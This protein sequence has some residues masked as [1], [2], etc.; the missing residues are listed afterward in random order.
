M[1]ERAINAFLRAVRRR[2]WLENALRALP[3]AVWVGA[4]V[5][6]TVAAVSAFLVPV[7]PVTAVIAAILAMLA[8]E[9]PAATRRPDL[10]TSALRA[11]RR[12]EGQALLA[13]AH[14]A[15]SNGYAD[16]PAGELVVQRAAAAVESW[17]GRLRSVWARPNP[18]PFV[19]ALI[20][21]FGAVLF[22]SKSDDVAVDAQPSAGQVEAHRV[23]LGAEQDVAA[24]RE[25][26][27][28][29]RVAS[30]E[31]AAP[32]T[33]DPDG[34]V[35]AIPASTTPDRR[36]IAASQA[37]QPGVAG[38]SAAGGAEA[39]D[40][41]RRPGQLAQHSSDVEF[42]DIRFRQIERRGAANAGTGSASIVDAPTGIPAS[43]ADIQ[44]AAAPPGIAS[45]NAMSA[46]QRAYARRYSGDSNDE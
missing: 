14:D 21:L 40:A 32:M 7:S 19:L 43:L 20:P 28:R 16:S 39:G 37:D 18:A 23:H 35:A 36:E 22:F 33:A 38:E 3:S 31:T 45:W 15:I 27:V 8:I 34:M 24:L 6:L 25:S 42:D 13:T 41:R 11:D 9:L 26:I 30:R 29:D 17:H 46:A 10:A 1:N 44:P 5:L 2:L 12:F 4:G